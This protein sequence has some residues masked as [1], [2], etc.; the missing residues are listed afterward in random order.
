MGEKISIRRIALS[1]GSA[2]LL[3][4]LF[5]A[6]V[7]YATYETDVIKNVI[8]GQPSEECSINIDQAKGWS[9]EANGYEFGMQYDGNI[10][11]TS[12]VTMTDWSIAIK[13]PSDTVVDSLWEGVYTYD[14]SI[15]TITPLDYNSEVFP[16]EG[17]S[18]GF[19]VH[20]NQF[21]NIL[22]ATYT[23]KSKVD[24]YRLPVFYVW[25]IAVLVYMVATIISLIYRRRTIQLEQQKNEYFNIIN[26]SF[27]TFANMIDAKDADT[28]GHSL[29]VAL[30]CRAIAQKLGYNE[31]EQQRIFYIGLL[32]DIGKIGTADAVLK[33]NGKLTNDEYS[34][35][36]EHVVIGGNIIKDFSAID[37]IE[38]GVRFHHERWDGKGYAEGLKGLEIPLRA[39]IVGIADAFDAMTS[40]RVYRK[41]LETSVAR[42]EL[43]RCAGTQFDPEIVPKMVELI[44]EGVVPI[45][46]EPETLYNELKVRRFGS[47]I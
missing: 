31:I 24:F 2:I 5:W 34:E 16:G 47:Y 22:E 6:I 44:D 38:A 19:V 36:V 11:N 13:L 7:A 12:P 26:Q 33:K 20:S 8:V 15:L 30:Y 46:L 39:R 43:I 42:E 10:V 29:R 32:H 28:R 18:F 21:S 4:L 35:M 40:D 27:L 23:Y 14:N 41:A 37:D 45:E 17:R 1:V 3:I 25:V 9:E